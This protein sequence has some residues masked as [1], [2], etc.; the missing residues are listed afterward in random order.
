MF[1]GWD[2][3]TSVIGFAAF[4]DDGDF[5]ETD[6]CDLSKIEGGL[7]D[8]ADMADCW[9]LGLFDRYYRKYG[10]DKLRWHDHF[11]EDRLAGFSGGGSNAGTVM[12]LAAFN[13]TVS[14]IIWNRWRQANGTVLHIHPSTVK[15]IMRKM[16]LVIEKGQD[17]KELTLKF[18]SKVESKF[19]VT[20]NK[21]GNPKPFNYDMADAYITGVAG[22]K[23][24]IVK[25]H[26]KFVNGA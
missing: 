8:K 22:S 16:G 7:L 1:F 23:K 5:I 13:S 6:H 21:N 2:I 26:R 9:V 3:S 17:K 25:G 14:W 19:N 12:R 4:D 10:E 20:L 15:A 24:F 11:V 18:V